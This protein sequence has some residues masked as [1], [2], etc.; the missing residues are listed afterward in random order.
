MAVEGATVPHAATGS[1][2]SGA[3]TAAPT[4]ALLV[5]LAVDAP[6]A[7]KIVYGAEFGK[8]WLS[9]EDPASSGSGA[10]ILT[11]DGIYK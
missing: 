6:T 9:K 11:R 2:S 1:G 5:T 3:A 4:A 8:I 7:E 10:Q